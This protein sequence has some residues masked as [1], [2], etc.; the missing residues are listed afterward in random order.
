MKDKGEYITKLHLFVPFEGVY[1]AFDFLAVQ[2]HIAKSDLLSLLEVSLL[3]LAGRFTARLCAIQ[4][5]AFSLLCKIYTRVLLHTKPIDFVVKQ[6]NEEL[7]S[8]RISTLNKL[9]PLCLSCVSK[10]N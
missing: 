4:T 7:F 3:L 10:L 5:P 8:L 1:M 6:F 2:T 9:I